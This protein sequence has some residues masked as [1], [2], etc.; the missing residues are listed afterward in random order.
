MVRPV[1]LWILPVLLAALTLCNL[2]GWT[3]AP[4]QVTSFIGIATLVIIATVGAQWVV[5]RR[6]PADRAALG[7]LALSVTVGCSAYI[8][9]GVTPILFDMSF[10]V[11]Q[12]HAIG[13]LLVIYV[14]LALGLN[15]FRLFEMG[16]WAYR[17]LFYT[18][19]TLLLVVI[20]AL[21]VTLLSI[22][23]PDHRLCL[24]AAA[25]RCRPQYVDL[26]QHQAAR[27]VLGRHRRRLCALGG[28][29]H[30]ALA[31]AAAPGV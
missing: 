25:R 10:G 21:L 5:T 23:D 22:V 13:L 14:G 29:T 4:D 16:D 17:V 19:G 18:L 28:G 26:S 27:A 1:W 24:S 7:W 31:I 2:A 6:N 20:D 9:I 30:H 15:R 12:S 11:S 8:V 3:G